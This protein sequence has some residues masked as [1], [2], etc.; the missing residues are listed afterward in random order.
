M[1]TN[2]P[3]T[4]G[5]FAIVDDGDYDFLMRWKWYALKDR[6]GY[7]AARYIRKLVDGKTIN[8]AVLMHR[9]I[10][11]QPKLMTDHINH[12][13]LDNRRCNLR[14]VTR[15][16]NMMNRVNHK[17]TI[18]KG[19]RKH[20]GKFQ[21]RIKVDGR[22]ISLG[23]FSTEADAANAYNRAAIKCFGEFAQ[24]NRAILREIGEEE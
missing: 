12:D 3:L 9:Q 23:V 22:V 18:A 24:P 5:L 8:S 15:E 17:R 20:H 11:G 19:V 14:V 21:S 16:Q 6:H 2:I 4:R 13:K 10:L 7:Y 1:S